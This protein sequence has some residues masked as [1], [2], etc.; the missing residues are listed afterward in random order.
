MRTLN[1][2]Q[3]LTGCWALITGGAGH[4]G[5]MACQTL[6][7]QGASVILLDRHHDALVAAKESFSLSNHQKVEVIDCDLAQES[8]IR[9]AIKSVAEI[10]SG[11]LHIV[12]NNAAFVGTDKLTGW[13]VPFEQQSFETFNACL[14]VNLSAPF[15]I[16]QL[17][18]PLLKAHDHAV[19]SVINI[20][21]IYGVVGPQMVMY[22]GTDMGNPAAYAASKAGLMQL[23]KWMACTVAPA[24]RVNNIVLGGVFRG[25]D[26]A[27]LEKYHQRVPLGRMAIEEDVKGAIAY[28]SSQLSN[29]MTGQSL[30]LDGGWTVH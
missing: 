11:Q 13:C 14:D 8:A 27:F 16:S 22:E 23:T 5:K 20:S 9:A 3:D 28:L 12:I 2:L 7:E 26:P 10:T 24:V 1:Q 21:S 15:L 4:I 25:Q 17:C 6:L 30:I 19:K 18:L 29:Y